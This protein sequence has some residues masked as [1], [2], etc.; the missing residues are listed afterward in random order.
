MFDVLLNLEIFERRKKKL[1]ISGRLS[2]MQY[3]L[4]FGQFSLYSQN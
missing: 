1:G 2:E 4:Q 3:T